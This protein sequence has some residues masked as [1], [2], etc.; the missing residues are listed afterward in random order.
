MKMYLGTKLLTAV[1]M[2]LGEYNKYQGL[3]LPS[4]QDGSEEGFL[5]EYQDGGKANH[6]NHKG[7]ISWSPKVAFNGAYR[8]VDGLNFGLAIEA[9]KKG[10]KVA[11]AG[12]NGKGI[13]V[14]L[15]DEASGLK[16]VVFNGEQCDVRLSQHLA[17]DTTGLQTDN[18]DAP[19][20]IVP[21]LASQSD[22][23]ADDWMII[24]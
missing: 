22:M 9:M 11:R 5:V 10:R 18:E 23:L 14:F 4:D 19:K 7:Y 20:S 8:E 24:E 2:T 3:D 6:P 15:V 13:H 21:W 12:W 17:I 1:A 16:R